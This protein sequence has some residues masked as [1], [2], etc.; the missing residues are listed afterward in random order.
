MPPPALMFKKISGLKMRFGGNA[1]SQ[2]NRI[3]NDTGRIDKHL[4]LALL[5]IRPNM[6]RKAGSNQ[7]NVV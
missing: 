4:E 7:Q 6:C 1:F 5:Q 2:R 3:V